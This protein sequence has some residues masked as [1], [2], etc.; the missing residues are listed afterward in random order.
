MIRFQM[1]PNPTIFGWS[2]PHSHLFKI[3]FDNQQVKDMDF[4]FLNV[5]SCIRIGILY[6][7]D[8]IRY[9]LI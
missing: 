4:S 7:I 8:L 3:A 5:A 1:L 6:K 2:Q 9:A